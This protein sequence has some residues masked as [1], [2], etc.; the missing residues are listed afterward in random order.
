MLSFAKIGSVTFGG[1]YAMIPVI[2]REIIDK[3]KWIDP[4]EF[5][6]LLTLAQSAPGPIVLNTSIFVGYRIDGYRG[7]ICSTLGVV[8]PSFIIILVIAMFFSK[9]KDNPGVIAV[10]KGM[11]PAVVALILSPIYSLSKG[12]GLTRYI[13]AA[14]AALGIWYFGF[15]PIYAIVV[16]AIGGILFFS[17]KNRKKS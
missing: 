3:R 1:G 4:K 12:L 10:F 6:E 2:Q 5:L 15:S 13:L 17:I 9:I 16:G 11:G 8:I 14:A 7:A